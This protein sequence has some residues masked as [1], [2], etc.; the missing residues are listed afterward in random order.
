MMADRRADNSTDKGSRDFFDKIDDVV[1]DVVDGKRY[2]ESSVWMMLLVVCALF[3][4]WCG[5]DD[6]RLMRGNTIGLVLRADC[7]LIV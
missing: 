1:D 4:C 3:L 6:E 5:G 2:D 7:D